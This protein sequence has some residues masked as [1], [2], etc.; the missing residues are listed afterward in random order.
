M[1]LLILKNDYSG[2]ELNNKLVNLRR[3][4]VGIFTK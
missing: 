4:K 1:F 2:K 3:G